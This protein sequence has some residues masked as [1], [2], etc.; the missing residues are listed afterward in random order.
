MAV[1]VLVLW[2]IGQSFNLMTLGG[3][4]AAIG[5]VIDDAIVVVE[6]FAHV[7]EQALPGTKVDHIVVTGVGDRLGAAKGAFVNLMLRHVRK[8]VPAW[9]LPGVVWFN[10]A[11]ALGKSGG[12]LVEAIPLPDITWDSFT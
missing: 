4:A 1:T 7:L 11:L 8:A 10:Q 5:L 6:N 3:L 2:A 9:D 12:L